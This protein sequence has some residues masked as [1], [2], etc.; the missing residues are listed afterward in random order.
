MIPMIHI[1]ICSCFVDPTSS[2]FLSEEDKSPHS[3]TPH[4]LGDPWE[5]RKRAKTSWQSLFPR[6]IVLFP[7]G[8]K[9][10][11][12]KVF[13]PPSTKS[14][15]RLSNEVDSIKI[16]IH[17]MSSENPYN[18]VNS[19][20]NHGYIPLQCPN[21]STH[22]SQISTCLHASCFAPLQLSPT[23]NVS[24]RCRFVRWQRSSSL[25]TPTHANRSSTFQ[26]SRSVSKMPR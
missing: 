5:N 18:T 8:R 16:Y 26:M 24:F 21:S 2:H 25:H 14:C 12:D 9:I 6:P 20:R 19:E 23:P 17:R 15:L 13:P 7:L 4:L 3:Q 10:M 1:F 11:D 22:A